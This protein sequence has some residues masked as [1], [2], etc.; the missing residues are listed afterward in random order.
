MKKK[1]VIIISIIF[2][3]IVILGV[4]IPTYKIYSKV[5]SYDSKIYP[6][7]KVDGEDLSGKTVEEAKKLLA[8]K[9]GTPI[10]NKKINIK[11]N[12]KTYTI[13]YAQLGAKYDI[14]KIVKEAYDYGKDKNI[15]D[16]YKLIKS[17]AQKT[18]KLSFTY[19]PKPIDDVINTIKTDVNKQPI[20]GSIQ[21]TGAMGV[22]AFAVSPDT[23][24][25]SL[26][27]AELKTNIVKSING[28]IG[29]D[30]NVQANIET[31][32]ASKTKEK[33]LG[34]NT[35]I[36]TYSTIYG[37]VSSPGRATNIQLATKAING[38]VLMP[39][40]TFSFNGVVGERTAAKGYQGAP[41]DIGK[42]TSMGLG[43]GICQ[44][45]T[46][47]Y[48]SIIRAG[49][50]ST[51][52]MHHTIPSTYVPLGFDATVDYGN[53]DYQFKNTLD[54][55]I[56]IE[57]S[58]DNGTEVFN[59]YSDSSR[60]STTYNLT[61]DESADHLNVK[62]YLQTIQNGAIIKNEL[63]VNDTYTK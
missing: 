51:V 53:L 27:D 37:P 55:P 5:K 32:K 38:L 1:N 36:S 42:T 41:V 40:E 62:V 29:K 13:N 25:Y 15:L 54:F 9:Y 28:E 39:G 59:V 58:S 11:V 10:G 61:R 2:S 52:R 21:K 60:L 35:L 46:T 6:T 7:V 3:V 33:L 4:S 12:G 43:G 48:N 57:A 34:V 50:K 49:I 17:S 22:A 31:L 8:D 63:I 18:M 20:N 47:L 19:N 16:K 56:Y 30:A 14:D 26:K 23:D 24:G 45:S 44:V